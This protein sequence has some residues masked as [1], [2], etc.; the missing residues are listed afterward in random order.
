MSKLPEDFRNDFYICKW[1]RCKK[2]NFII[3]FK[4]YLNL[5]AS[6]WDVDFAEQRLLKV[7]EFK[8]L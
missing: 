4:K 7:N 3:P 1:L 6:D 2:N 5:L 8:I